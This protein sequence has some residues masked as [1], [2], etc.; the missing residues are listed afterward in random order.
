V[1]PPL[2]LWRS[3]FMFSSRVFFLAST[4]TSMIM[5]KAWRWA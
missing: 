2:G 1:Q 3:C 5:A 4:F